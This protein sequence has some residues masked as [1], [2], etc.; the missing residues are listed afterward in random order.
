M[1]RLA[2]SVFCSS[3]PLLDS[4]RTRTSCRRFRKLRVRRRPHPEGL[5][6]CALSGREGI[7]PHNRNPARCA[8]RRDKLAALSG[9]EQWLCVIFSQL[10]NVLV[11]RA[12]DT[13]IAV[14]FSSASS[15]LW[16]LTQAQR[17]Q[18]SEG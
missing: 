9:D 5:D 4:R 14:A 2:C 11:R 18:L 6:V 13:R 15:E 12:V 17:Q 10:C 3:I 7:S 16:A 1:S 8:A